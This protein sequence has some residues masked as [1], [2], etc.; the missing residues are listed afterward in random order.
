SGQPVRSAERERTPHQDARYQDDR[1][2]DHEVSHDVAAARADGANGADLFRARADVEGGETKDT[3]TGDGE[4]EG[5][6]GRQEDHHIAILGIESLL[7]VV[8][9]VR[10]GD[11]AVQTRGGDVVYYRLH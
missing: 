10:E 11:D 8:E 5:R 2:L 6:D 7:E 3:E 4:D 1:V 9:G